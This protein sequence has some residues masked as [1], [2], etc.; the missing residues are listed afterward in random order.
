[1]PNIASLLKTE[2]A[3][4]ARKEIRANVD[5]LRKT[6]SSQRSQIAA[7]KRRLDA[8]ERQLKRVGKSVPRAAA[9]PEADDGDAAGGN[10]F[11]AKG[12]KSLR[13]RLGLSALDFGRLIGASA[14]SVYKWES[15]KSRPRAKYVA[16]IAKVR[17]IG[18]KEATALLEAAQ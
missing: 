8:A 12:L 6:V 18:K 9:A 3:R 13:A 7:L 10:R 1:M 4:V 16:S 2:I 15:G 5:E 14:L 11:S 17:G